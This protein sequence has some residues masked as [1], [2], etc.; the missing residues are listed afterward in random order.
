MHTDDWYDWIPTGFVQLDQSMDF[1][2][3]IIILYQSLNPFLFTILSL[4]V[5]KIFQ[6]FSNVIVKMCDAFLLQNWSH[7]K[8][9]YCYV[10]HFTI[11]LTVNPFLVQTSQSSKF[12]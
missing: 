11:I 9:N 7:L 4:S 2:V 10:L 1:I 8:N 3:S 6:K 5:V 12:K